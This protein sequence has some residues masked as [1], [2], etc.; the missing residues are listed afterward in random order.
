MAELAVIAPGEIPPLWRT[1]LLLVQVRGGPPR[2]GVDITGRARQL[3]LIG[4]S[5][6]LFQGRLRFI[7]GRPLRIGPLAGFAPF[8]RDQAEADGYR[9]H[10]QAGQRG[11]ARMPSA[12]F[13]QPLDLSGRPGQDRLAAGPAVQVVGQR[14]GR[15][16]PPL[17][18][19]FQAFQTDR[20]Q[21]AVDVGIQCPRPL[22]ARA[23]A[24]A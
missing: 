16:V 7:L 23:R 18:L 2:I 9:Q 24:P 12:P 4:E 1:K 8:P 17:R 19:L 10:Q 5:L 13:R 21:V 11:H 15:V 6:R 22:A 20:F 3:G 14:G